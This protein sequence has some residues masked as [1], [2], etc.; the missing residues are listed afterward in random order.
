MKRAPSAEEIEA[1]APLSI[2]AANCAAGS[3]DDACGAAGAELSAAECSICLEQL[4]EGQPV[5][6]LPACSHT[7]HALC[8]GRW[9]SQLCL[10]LPL[11]R[12]PCCRK[13]VAIAPQWVPAH[14]VQPSGS[15]PPAANTPALVPSTAVAT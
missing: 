8:I 1:G 4:Q 12:C 5:R 3:G 13:T 15:Q 7:F 14:A 2:Y 9:F 10:A 11:C 6:R